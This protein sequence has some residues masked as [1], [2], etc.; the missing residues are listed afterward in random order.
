MGLLKIIYLVEY[1]DGLIDCLYP[2]D[3]RIFTESE[4]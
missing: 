1:Q 4:T 3:F 2:S